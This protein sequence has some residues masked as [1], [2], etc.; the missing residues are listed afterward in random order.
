MANTQ[1]YYETEHKLQKF[2]VCNLQ[3][4]VRWAISA[5]LKHQLCQLPF[6]NLS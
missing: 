2:S 5:L 1:V 6:E 3:S 4:T